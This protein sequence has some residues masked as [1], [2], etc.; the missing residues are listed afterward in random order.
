MTG[1]QIIAIVIFF[2]FLVL[3]STG[4]QIETTKLSGLTNQSNEN[5]TIFTQSSGITDISICDFDAGNV[6][7][8]SD[9]LWG[10]DCVADNVGFL[11]SFGGYNT[12]ILWLQVLFVAFI[13]AL[14]Y[15]G[16]KVIRG[17]G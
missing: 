7:L 11:F 5:L 2:G 9:F 17:G 6:P 1:R 3:L 13:M 12:T 4:F 14:V 8:L 10:M 15:V 16:V